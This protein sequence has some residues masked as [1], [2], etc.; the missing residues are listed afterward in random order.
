MIITVLS[1]GKFPNSYKVST[2][3][4]DVYASKSSKLATNLVVGISYE[5]NLWK[6]DGK[7]TTYITKAEETAQTLAPSVEP[8]HAPSTVPSGKAYPDRSVKQTL[9]KP[10]TSVKSTVDSDKM[11]K[12]DWQKKD[13]GIKWLSVLKSACE[14]SR[15][16]AVDPSE[17]LK[18]AQKFY[19]Y[20]P[21]SKPTTV[22]KEGQEEYG[23]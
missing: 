14:Y 17:I 9:D 5:A 8:S 23:F 7:K 15:G 18:I 16:I 6:P 10:R 2:P 4:G 11:S 13:K 1:E 22:A 12:A 21:D 3:D 19:D 20:N